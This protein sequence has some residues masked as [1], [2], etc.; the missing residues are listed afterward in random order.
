MI[1]EH[2]YKIKLN[3]LKQNVY[4]MK[5]WNRKIK[6]YGKRFYKNFTFVSQSSGSIRTFKFSILA[7]N[8]SYEPSSTETGIP[9]TKFVLTFF[10]VPKI[11]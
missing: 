7:Q 8:S 4:D 5:S 6:L 10:C 9:S 2:D 1:K 11:Y 3:D